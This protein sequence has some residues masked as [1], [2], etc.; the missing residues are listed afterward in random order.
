MSVRNL[1][2]ACGLRFTTDGKDPTASAPLY[3]GPITLSETAE[4]KLRAFAADGTARTV[5]PVTFT[6]VQPLRAH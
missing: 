1:E 5:M 3:T 4:L 6:K 2:P